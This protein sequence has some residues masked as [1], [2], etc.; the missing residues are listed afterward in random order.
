MIQHFMFL[1]FKILR[2]KHLSA[3]IQLVTEGASGQLQVNPNGTVFTRSVGDS[4]VFTCFLHVDMIDVIVNI[5]WLN[6]ARIEIQDKTPGR[7]K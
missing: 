1:Y 5:Q 4:V 7:D 2:F 6:S 3:E